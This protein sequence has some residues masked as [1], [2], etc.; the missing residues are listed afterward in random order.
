MVTTQSSRKD[1]RGRD[2]STATLLLFL[3]I[4]G[5]GV[6]AWYW[7]S[8]GVSPPAG[9]ERVPAEVVAPATNTTHRDAR[10]AGAATETVYVVESQERADFI[11]ASLNEAEAFAVLSGVR[12]ATT[13]VVVLEAGENA[14]ALFSEAQR[15]GAKQGLPA[16]TV[17]DLRPPVGVPPAG[18]DDT[19]PVEPVEQG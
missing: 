19:G 14:A 1:S 16:F 10:P 2:Y 9:T 4:V 6:L 3:L 5:T 8:D 17:V 13:S 18:S 7:T 15:M 11:R 12:P